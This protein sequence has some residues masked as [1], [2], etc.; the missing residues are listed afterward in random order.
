[1][2]HQFLARPLY[3]YFQGAALSGE[4]LRLIFDA[5]ILH[6]LDDGDQRPAKFSQRIF[7]LWRNL[8]IH[9][10][11]NH[12]VFLKLPELKRQ[13]TLGNAGTDPA[14]FIEPSGGIHEM[15]QKHT[16]PFAANDVE[17]EFNRTSGSLAF[18]TGAEAAFAIAQY[19]TRSFSIILYT[20]YHKCAYFTS[21]CIS[22]TISM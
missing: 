4:L 9:L 6:Q 16:L 22:S 7:N 19:R 1:M 12:A 8:M 3:V 18:R 10:A 11:V 2:L 20:T 13:H 17:G 21:C 14:E 5:P 15:I